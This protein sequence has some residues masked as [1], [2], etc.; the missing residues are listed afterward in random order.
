M[1]DVLWKSDE[2]TFVRIPGTDEEPDNRL[3]PERVQ[4]FAVTASYLKV[5]RIP[6]I[7]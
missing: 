3:D 2:I 5:I 4:D 6:G 1:F 7:P